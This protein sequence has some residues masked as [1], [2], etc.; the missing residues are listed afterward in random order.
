L[1]EIDYIVSILT[2]DD[3]VAMPRGIRNRVVEARDP[4]SAPGVIHPVKMQYR[5]NVNA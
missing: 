3:F 4:I 5:E 1:S 2:T